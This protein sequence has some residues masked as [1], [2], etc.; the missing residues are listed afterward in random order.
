MVKAPD[1]SRGI[2]NDKS[3]SFKPQR[4]VKARLLNLLLFLPLQ[5]PSFSILNNFG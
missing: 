5:K 3:Q 4:R 1:V 2:L